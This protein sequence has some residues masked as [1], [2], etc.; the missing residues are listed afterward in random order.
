MTWDEIKELGPFYA[1]GAVDD[2]TARSIEDFL[3][4]A[5][6][7]QQHEIRELREVAAL[8]PLALPLPKVPDIIRDRLFVRI[9]GEATSTTPVVS[10]ETQTEYQ[11]DQI[12]QTAGSEE[13]Y[14]ESARVL[15][16]TQAT[17]R[18]EASSTRWL[19]LA[20]TIL[21]SFTSGYLLWRNY[22]LH[23]ENNQLVAENVRVRSEVDE[24]VSPATK[25]ITMAGQETPQ[26]SAK[27]VWDTNRQTWAIYI[28]NLPPPPTDKQYQLWYVKANAKISAA[29]FDTNPLGDKVLRLEL[30]PDAVNGLAAT[31]VTLEPRG[32]SKQPTSNLYLL[33]KI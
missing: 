19:L 21:L 7:E 9:S 15:A 4:E 24:I 3:Q 23:H 25:I 32:G 11:P 16:F 1:L 12:D 29:V 14:Q 27:L 5:T 33:G 6:P 17:P 22:Q 8:L 20:A 26:A 28:F 18:R 30:P 10:D 13:P 2:D 31:A